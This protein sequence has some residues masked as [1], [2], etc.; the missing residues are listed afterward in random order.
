[1]TKKD[2]VDLEL[3]ESVADDCF[4]CNICV[5]EC[6]FLQDSGTPGE[7]CDMFLSGHDQDRELFYRCNL[8]G[9]CSSVCPKKIDSSAAFLEIRR[10]L[11]DRRKTILPAHRV[12]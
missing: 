8:C 1:M 12:M 11:F 10:L 2:V 4:K 7:L 9:L 6:A 5:K 3:I